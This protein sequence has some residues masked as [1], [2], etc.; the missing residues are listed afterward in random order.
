MQDD[1]CVYSANR[2]L[3]SSIFDTL[4]FVPDPL[5]NIPPR[6]TTHHKKMKLKKSVLLL[7]TGVID[8]AL[9][10]LSCRR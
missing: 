4:S 7:Y 5:G 1:L 9:K 6:A 3:S 2:K 8:K 10:M